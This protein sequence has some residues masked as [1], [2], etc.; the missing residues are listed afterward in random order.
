[1]GARIRDL[2]EQ[3]GIHR[4]TVRRLLETLIDEG[5][6]RQSYSD[7]SY[8]LTIKVRELSEGFRDEQWISQLAAPLLGQLMQDVV[9]PTDICTF[10]VD[11]MVVRETTHKFSRLSFHRNM[12]GRRL[13]MLKSATGRAYLAF[14]PE[15]ERQSI[16]S[17]LRTRD[18]ENGSMARDEAF[19]HRV[20]SRTRNQGYGA[21]YGDWGEEGKIA[22]IALPIKNKGRV[23]GCLNLV[24]IKQA[25]TIEEAAKKHL[26]R[27][28]ET[29]T[30]IEANI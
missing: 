16:L 19:V 3:S 28:I 27:M 24:Y 12:V 9:W 18:G 4:T 2:A 13:P 6:V 14:C 30:H 23:L 20:L 26:G 25:M 7:D 21:N 22:A 17:L 5:Y 15:N 11:A 8:Q 10:D 1:G 29:V